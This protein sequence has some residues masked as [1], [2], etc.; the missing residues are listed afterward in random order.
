MS[1]LVCCSRAVR[2]REQALHGELRQASTKTP[3]LVLAKAL[4]GLFMKVNETC[5]S[6][7]LITANM[8]VSRANRRITPK[9]SSLIHSWSRVLS[10]VWKTPA[11]VN[12]QS[13]IASVR[14]PISVNQKSKL[15]VS[16]AVIPPAGTRDFVS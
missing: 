5:Q 10:S 4:C 1:G 16:D 15:K 9:S 7:I 13:S 6:I 8:I 12:Q 3:A 2:Q 11:S 14:I